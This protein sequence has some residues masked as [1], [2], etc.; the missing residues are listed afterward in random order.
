MDLLETAVGLSGPT[1]SQVVR[2]AA[3]QRKL[4][5]AAKGVRFWSASLAADPWSTSRLLLGWRD[6]LIEGGWRPE[7]AGSARLSDLAAAESSGPDLPS[8]PADR[9]AALS[10]GV[11]ARAARAI[12]R[13]R[14][15]DPRAELSPGMAAADRRP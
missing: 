14:L 3:W 5:A 1:E 12:R 11:D 8:G 7:V 6:A 10:A 2:I 13:L 4:E 9:L 15:I